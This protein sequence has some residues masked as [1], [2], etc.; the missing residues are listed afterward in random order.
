M[1]LRVVVVLLR[2][3]VE[4]DTPQLANSKGI[5]RKCFYLFKLPTANPRLRHA[6]HMQERGIAGA[7]LLHH[8]HKLLCFNFQVNAIKRPY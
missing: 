7:G 8:S 5:P 4:A 1:R 2:L 6:Q 3:R